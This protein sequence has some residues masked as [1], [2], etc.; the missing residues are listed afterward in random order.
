MRMGHA[1][2]LTPMIADVLAKAGLTASELNRVA[3]TRGPGTFTG[4]R[5]G[6]AAARALCLAT[7][8]KGV[9]F[10]SFEVIAQAL[11]STAA[12]G[13]SGTGA[14]ARPFV[15]V[16]P[17][18]RGTFDSQIFDGNAQPLCPPA[19]TTAEDLVRQL[20]KIAGGDSL[21]KLRGVGTGAEE[22]AKAFKALG[23]PITVLNTPD[24]SEDQQ[25]SEPDAKYL[26]S[27]AEGVTPDQDRPLTP[28]YLRPPDAKPSSKPSIA[29]R[30]SQW[31]PT[32]VKDPA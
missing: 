28:L 30:S 31:A 25:V 7:G 20:Q 6:I 5:I 4:T 2:A 18:R 13:I 27:L 17:E 32:V 29:R 9:G 14:E 23:Q 22:L 15:V 12:C 24:I 26:L 21:D 3:V 8:A 16:R 19:A 1:E 11:K 10:T